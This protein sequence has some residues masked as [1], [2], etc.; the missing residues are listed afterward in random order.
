VLLSL[1]TGTKRGCAGVPSTFRVAVVPAASG[2][3]VSISS[4]PPPGSSRRA[5]VSLTTYKT[6]AVIVCP[7]RA[8]SDAGIGSELLETAEIEVTGVI[9]VQNSLRRAR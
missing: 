7:M 3:S 6:R 5:V 4:V 1:A 9:G 8:A 2:A